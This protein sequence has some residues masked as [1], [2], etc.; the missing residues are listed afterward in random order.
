MVTSTLD[1]IFGQTEAIRVLKGHLSSASISHAYLFLGPKGV[2]K[3]TAALAFAAAINCLDG[4]CGICRSCV[5]ISGA[6]HPDI[7]II[8]AGGNF[9]TIDQ[10]R[11]VQRDAV[12]KPFEAECKVY[13]IEEIERMTKEASNALLKILEE[14]PNGVMFILTAS[15]LSSVLDTISSRCSHILFRHL[16]KEAMAEAILRDGG[17]N[18]ERCALAIRL[19]QGVFGRAITMIRDD[20]ELKRR[21]SII[22]FIKEL[23]KLDE[24]AL[25]DQV[26]EL[27]ESVKDKLSAFEADQQAE[28]DEIHEAGFGPAQTSAMVKRLKLKHKRET[29]KKETELFDG[30]FSVISSWYRDQAAIL[31]KAGDETLINLDAVADLKGSL[32]GSSL[33]ETM[34]RLSVI[35]KTKRLMGQNVNKR[36]ALEVMFFELK[37]AGGWL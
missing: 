32:A 2:G 15:N 12:I 22:A 33:A 24:L 34:R 23:D 16:A 28:L 5:K 27:I 35:I 31:C 37:G 1:G 21:D 4:G 14:P 8:Q 29:A 3:M 36:L 13:V 19:S 10:V 9:I 17:G 30:I 26:E 18:K 6:L 25:A 11:E 20:Y 7:L